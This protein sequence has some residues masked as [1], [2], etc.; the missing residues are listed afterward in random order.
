MQMKKL[1]AIFL[2]LVMVLSV[3]SLS[4]FADTTDAKPSITVVGKNATPGTDITFDVK[5]ANFS[6]V[7]GMDIQI[8]G[9][10][11][12]EFKDITS[13]DV[14]LTKDSNYTLSA[15]EIRI[16]ELNDKSD[17]TLKVTAT[18]KASATVSVKVKL[19]ANATELVTEYTTVNGELTAAA[20]TKANGAGVRAGSAPYGLRFGLEASCTGVG[21]PA[22]DTYV[23][24]Y[25]NAKVSINGVPRKVLRVG[26]I[27]AV[28]D[29]ATGKELVAGDIT[30]E[31]KAY[32]KNVEAVKAYEVTND[33]VSY[34]V[35][36]TGIPEDAVAKSITVRPYVAY[37]DAAGKTQYTY[38]TAFTSSVQSV[39]DKLALG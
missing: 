26:A 9:A 36:V 39:R 20:I 15:T 34:V 18:V 24:D 7:K 13:A 2:A 38:G 1:A 14:T 23:V 35:T 12:V 21:Q 16:V 22:K 8:L 33:T 3:A 28:T 6:N 11:G 32:I 29:K 5:L 17:L 37:E 31:T 4:A 10:N 25:S 19:A 27:V 30:D